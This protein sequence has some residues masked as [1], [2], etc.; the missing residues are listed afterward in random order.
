[1]KKLLFFSSIL[2]I[3]SGCANLG[4]G[5]L[6]G[7]MERPVWESSVPFGMLYI[8]MGS[9]SMGPSEQDIP[10]AMNAQNKTVSLQAFWMDE[11]E[12]TNNV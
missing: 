2:L 8:P 12:I 1:M 5:E 9:F 7:V 4:D 10:W 3:F 11:T 6:T